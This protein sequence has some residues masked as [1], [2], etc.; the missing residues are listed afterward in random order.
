MTTKRTLVASLALLAL[1]AL[2]TACGGQ[3]DAG[4]DG[5]RTAGPATAA[6]SAAPLAVDPVAATAPTASVGS[7]MD[8]L[9]DAPGVEYAPQDVGYDAVSELDGAAV[10]RLRINV[11]DAGDGW[12]QGGWLWVFAD[13]AA[14]EA[15][16]AAALA[17]DVQAEDVPRKT[18]TTSVHGNVVW[19]QRFALEPTPDEQDV[20]GCLDATTT[21]VTAPGTVRP[22]TLY[23]CARAY[24]DEPYADKDWNDDEIGRWGRV[25]MGELGGGRQGVEMHVF[26]DAASADAQRRELVRGAEKRSVVAGNVVAVFDKTLDTTDPATQGVLSCLPA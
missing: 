26:R 11:E 19:V 18:A 24:A 17:Q 1:G 16:A 13:G 7:L 21:P 15:G 3:A 6:A 9:S 12:S 10:D 22:G 25:L 23:D 14:A 5:S 8:C 20:L 2:A 4:P